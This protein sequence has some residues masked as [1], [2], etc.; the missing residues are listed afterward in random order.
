MPTTLDVPR[1]ASPVLA[2]IEASFDL[3]ARSADAAR[4]PSLGTVPLAELHT[5]FNHRTTTKAWK[6]QVLLELLAAST[7]GDELALRTIVRLFIPAAVSLARSSATLRNH[8]R[9]DALAMAVSA[10]WEAARTYPIRRSRKPI[11]N[12]YM[13]ALSILSGGRGTGITEYPVEAFFFEDQIHPDAHERTAEQ[14]LAEVLAWALESG[15]LTQDEVR[16]LVSY[17]LADDSDTKGARGDLA[18]RLGVSRSALEKR[19]S[20]L[21]SKLV[22]NV[23]SHIRVEG[24]W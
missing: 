5:H 2:A 24:R 6:E 11:E 3:M 4:F 18:T 17:F 14:E 20:R 13:T 9:Q 10:V 21:R 23:Q 22:D 19:A 12:L 16:F 15:A 1:N 8:S 7:T